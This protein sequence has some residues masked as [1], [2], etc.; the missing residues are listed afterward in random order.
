M[1]K[2]ITKGKKTQKSTAPITWSVSNVR[3]WDD[4]GVTFALNLQVAEGRM[5]TVYGCRIAEGQEGAFISF[6]S[7]KGKD[8]KYYSHAYFRLTAKEQEKIIQ[9]ALEEVGLE[10]EDEDDED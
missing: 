6:P 7:R 8:G 2:T 5:V 10:E 1:A 4:G 9:A 3:A